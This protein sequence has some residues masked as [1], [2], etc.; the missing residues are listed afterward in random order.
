MRSRLFTLLAVPTVIL[1][2]LTVWLLAS[3]GEAQTPKKVA[4]CGWG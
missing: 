2:A 4:C 1:A 3:P